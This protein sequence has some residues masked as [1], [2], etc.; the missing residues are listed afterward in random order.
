MFEKIERFAEMLVGYP[1]SN[2][3]SAICFD[4]IP[5]L[6]DVHAENCH[7]CRQVF[8]LRVVGGLMYCFADLGRTIEQVH[9]NR[10]DV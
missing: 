2:D 6:C 4:C 3:S 7:V 10:T 8:V 9:R 1:C 5:R